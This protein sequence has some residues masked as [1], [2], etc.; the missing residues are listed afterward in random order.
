MNIRKAAYLILFWSLILLSKNSYSQESDLYLLELKSGISVKCHLISITDNVIYGISL[1]GNK[2]NVQ[3]SEVKSFE[4]IANDLTD[5]NSINS[6]EGKE[7]FSA[8][9]KLGIMSDP[10]NF[11]TPLFSASAVI[12][13]KLNPFFIG[14][15]VS[16]DR[17]SNEMVVPLFFDA[18]Y[19]LK[20]FSGVDPFIFADIGYNFG[21][22]KGRMLSGGVGITKE[23]SKHMTMIY[24]L[25]YKSQLYNY[26]YLTSG[27]QID[28]YEV[29]SE[30]GYFTF[31]V[32][33]QF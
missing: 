20:Q 13:Y 16:A 32:G 25:G 21:Y 33:L 23:F 9:L 24:E 27:Y 5:K 31:N 8:D 29:T 10:K 15:G 2:F 26:R 1:D 11:R 18:K 19:K 28:I 17:I 14:I 22:G 3:M 30:S 7:V 12:D 6:L 4:R